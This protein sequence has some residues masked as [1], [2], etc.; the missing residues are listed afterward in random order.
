MINHTVSG[1]WEEGD[2]R[3]QNGAVWNMTGPCQRPLES[4][5]CCREQEELLGNE[6][7]DSFLL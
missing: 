7:G 3:H 2:F 6:T 1:E 4:R 5:R